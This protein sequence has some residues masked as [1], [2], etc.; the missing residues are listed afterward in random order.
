MLEKEIFTVVFLSIT[1]KS[2]ILSDV[3]YVGWLAVIF[4]RL[5]CPT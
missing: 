1:D 5:F 2:K 4:I 3:K